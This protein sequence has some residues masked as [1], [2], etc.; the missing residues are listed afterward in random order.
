MIV[1]S[2]VFSFEASNRFLIST[3]CLAHLDSLSAENIITDLPSYAISSYKVSFRSVIPRNHCAQLFNF[4]TQNIIL[5]S[6]TSPLSTKRRNFKL[7]MNMFLR[8]K[9]FENA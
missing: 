9:R 7:V 6:K 8:S 3:C 4:S 2:L 5:S 1:R